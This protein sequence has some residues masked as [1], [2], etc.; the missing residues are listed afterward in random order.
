MKGSRLIISWLIGICVGMFIM[1][2]CCMAKIADQR[3]TI[4]GLHEMMTEAEYRYKFS[5]DNIAVY[6]MEINGGE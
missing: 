4:Q 3:E 5:F 1:G 6:K 2:L